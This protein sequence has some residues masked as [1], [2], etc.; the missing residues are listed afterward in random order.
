MET[1]DGANGYHRTAFAERDRAFPRLAF[2]APVSA[3]LTRH[4]QGGRSPL[5][6]SRARNG[7]CPCRI[8][9]G[10]SAVRGD[11]DLCARRSTLA[12]ASFLVCPWTLRWLWC[13]QR[14]PSAQRES[15]HTLGA[16]VSFPRPVRSSGCERPERASEGAIKHPARTKGK[17]GE[18]QQHWLQLRAWHTGAAQ[19]R[20]GSGDGGR[21][22]GRLLSAV[23][24]YFP[25]HRAKTV[26]SRRTIDS[27][28]A[29][30]T[31]PHRN[32]PPSKTGDRDRRIPKTPQNPMNDNMASQLDG[33]PTLEPTVTIVTAPLERGTWEPRA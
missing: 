15:D 5:A 4:R 27:Q 19:P 23:K 24:S 8:A 16:L 22:R 21:L 13:A 20:L 26:N 17:L 9:T 18:G 14:L 1:L 31:R 11:D 32:P 10:T 29:A 33:S 30:M 28:P 12:L 6:L 25:Y 2:W 3:P 7:R